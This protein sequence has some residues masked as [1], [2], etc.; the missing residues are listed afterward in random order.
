[1]IARVVSERGGDVGMA[2]EAQT[3][4]AVFLRVAMTDLL[5]NRNGLSASISGRSLGDI[6][7]QF[8]G[9]LLSRG[10]GS[11][12]TSVAASQSP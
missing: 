6:V 5:S 3:L 4:M 11:L 2:V 10:S 1:M 9:T 8:K 7:H 12:R